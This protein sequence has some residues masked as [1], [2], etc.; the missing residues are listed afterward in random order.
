MR[1]GIWSSRSTRCLR[2]NKSVFENLGFGAKDADGDPKPQMFKLRL[3]FVLARRSRM[4]CSS[5]SDAC[6]S[7]P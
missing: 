6:R 1:C 5:M 3:G 4:Q 2:R 7:Q